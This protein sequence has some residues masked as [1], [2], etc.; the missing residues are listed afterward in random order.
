[1]H[2][3]TILKQ[4]S[5]LS[6]INKGKKLRGNALLAQEIFLCVQECVNVVAIVIMHT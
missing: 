3:S 4:P 5:Q 1:M 6:F 2:A